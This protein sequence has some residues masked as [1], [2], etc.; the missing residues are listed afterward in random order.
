MTTIP[1][2][3]GGRVT[4]AEY[5]RRLAEIQAE[6]L[7]CSKAE[8]ARHNAEVANR[9]AVFRQKILALEAECEGAS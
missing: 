2:P 9:R 8:D 6:L 7:E 3:P 4:K 5:D 1:E